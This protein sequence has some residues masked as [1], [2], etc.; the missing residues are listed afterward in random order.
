MARYKLTVEF[1][2]SSYFGWQRQDGQA[3]IQQA[4]EEAVIAFQQQSSLVYG[5]GRTDAGVH[6]LGMVAHVDLWRELP[7]VNVAK[8][9]NAHLRPH[10]IAVLSA[11]PVP[12]DFHAR[13]SCVQR[14]YVYRIVN[15]LAP[16]ALDQ[17]RVWTVH[18]PLDVAAMQ[19]AARHLPGKHDFSTFRASS[20][21]SDSPLKTLDSLDVISMS[22][23]AG[24]QIEIHCAARSFLHHQVRNM[25]GSLA[26][27]GIGRWSISDFLEAFAAR[28]RTKGGP[29]AP[30][31]GLYF[32]AARY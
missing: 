3:S 14:S 7:G 4:L 29:T 2:G 32:Q 10:P 19:Q 11:E 16:A 5:A 9:L 31:E 21:Q 24:Q 13:F 15:R 6:A 1:D 18:Q 30:A 20:C 12:D 17:D 27:V 26:E 23:A 8:A 28:D 25:V 22:S